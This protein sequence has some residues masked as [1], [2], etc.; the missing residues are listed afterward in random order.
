[1]NRRLSRTEIFFRDHPRLDTA[2]E[3]VGGILLFTGFGF[4]T[5]CVMALG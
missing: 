2:T 3:I 1:M 5:I 4:L